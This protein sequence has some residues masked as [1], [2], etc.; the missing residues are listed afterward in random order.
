MRLIVFVISFFILYSAAAETKPI[1]YNRFHGAVG[2]LNIYNI[3]KLALLGF[4]KSF[5]NRNPLIFGIENSIYYNNKKY[6]WP[7]VGLYRY[8]RLIDVA[9][10]SFGFQISK[11][12]KFTPFV[13]LCYNY[14]LYQGKLVTDDELLKEYLI[15]DYK[16]EKKNIFFY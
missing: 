10:F 3:V 1:I 2:F 4:H 7:D 6:D 11:F 8:Q 14:I 9:S 12:I 16:F 13:G 15:N 5:S